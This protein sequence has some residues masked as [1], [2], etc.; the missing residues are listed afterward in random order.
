MKLAEN[1]LIGFRPIIEAVNAGKEIEK[2]LFKSGSTGELYHE[3]F[4]LVRKNN[5]PFQVVPIEKLNRI[6]RKNHQGIIAFVSVIEYSNIENLLPSLFENSVNPLIVMLDQVS[7]VRNFGAIAR[8]AECAGANAII[9]AEKGMAQINYD[10]IKTSAGALL[11]IPVCRTKSMM[12][13]V[14]FVKNSG[15]KVF[16][17]T[18]KASINIYD[19]DFSVPT[20][21][22]LGSEEKGISNDLLC[23]SDELVKIPILGTV[24]SLNVSVAASVVLYE[25]I[26]QRLYK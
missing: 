22:I 10:A 16:A 21:I 19:A 3:T 6:T 1:I 4:D 7:D 20:A 9:V 18:E 2:V 25:A 13:T 24:E 15:L 8:S 17:S 5:I 26:R 23:N 11:K 14:D 12:K